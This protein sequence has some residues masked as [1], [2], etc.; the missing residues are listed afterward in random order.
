VS[1][2]GER[3]PN[4]YFE[5]HSLCFHLNTTLGA[6]ILKAK[7]P[8]TCAHPEH[9]ETLEPMEL[10]TQNIGLEKHRLSLILHDVL[11][12]P[13]NSALTAFSGPTPGSEFWLMHNAPSEEV[14]A[15]G[16]L[17]H[18]FLYFSSCSLPRNLCSDSEISKGASHRRV[19]VF[20]LWRAP[21]AA[22]SWQH[23]DNAVSG[24]RRCEAEAFIGGQGS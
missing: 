7:F 19:C 9:V 8:L 24:C 11:C 13:I 5:Y 10:R 21:K 17:R 3:S 14:F 4:S 22:C 15:D 16:V 2:P 1:A 20:V 18:H 23:G 12:T 6:Q